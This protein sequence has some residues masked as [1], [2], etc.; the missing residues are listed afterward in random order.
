M[1]VAAAF[2]APKWLVDSR[3]RKFRCPPTAR[4]LVEA[5]AATFTSGYNDT[6]RRP[7]L[8]AAMAHAR[9]NA[10]EF[11]KPFYVEGASMALCVAHAVPCVSVHATRTDLINHL[12][13]Y[14]HVIYA[15]WGWG[16]AID[17]RRAR[18]LRRAIDAADFFCA[19]TLDGMAF[20]RA[21]L[22]AAPPRFDV[23]VPAVSE[24]QQRVWAQ[25]YGRALWF[26]A[27][28]DEAIIEDQRIRLGPTLAPEL[29]A[30]L[31]LAAGFAGMGIERS[32][33]PLADL[34]RRPSYIQG[35]AFGLTARA[36]S[37]PSVFANWR[38]GL[39]QRDASDV[40]RLIDRCLVEPRGVDEA[41]EVTY[42]A[43]QSELRAEFARTWIPA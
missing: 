42:T 15:G 33:R 39:S 36:S 24:A 13:G 16:H 43:W 27:G 37:T 23:A 40:T 41:P 4:A 7:D 9:G 32:W 34:A 5:I 20:A 18:A 14:K 31:G 38:A 19:I 30:G 22:F 10:D 11:L 12:P 6:L 26:L 2:R 8:T 21:F 1:T 35:L 17:P 29:D 28:A 3:V 25:G